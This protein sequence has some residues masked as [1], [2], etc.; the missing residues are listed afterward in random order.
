[1][2]KLAAI[3]VAAVITSLFALSGAK[4]ECVSAP[5]YKTVTKNV[6][7]K[8]I[9]TKEVPVYRWHKKRVK[10]KVPCATCEQPKAEIVKEPEPEIVR[11]KKKIVVIEE[12]VYEYRRLPQT[13]VQPR[14]TMCCPPGGRQ[15]YLPPCVPGQA[16]MSRPALPSRTDTGLAMNQPGSAPAG[17]HPCQQMVGG[18]MVT[19]KCW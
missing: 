19:G 17:A 11:V 8:Q 9:G 14:P 7:G 3:I 15:T 16:S 2:K 6:R 18:R 1:M 12:P 13:I 4:A 5:C 10:V